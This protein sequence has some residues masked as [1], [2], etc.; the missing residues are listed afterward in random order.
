MDAY[1]VFSSYRSDPNAKLK[2]K[3]RSDPKQKIF[4]SISRCSYELVWSLFTELDSRRAF[5]D[6]PTKSELFTH[7]INEMLGFCALEDNDKKDPLLY[8]WN[9]RD[10]FN[11]SLNFLL[12]DRF[13]RNERITSI[14]LL[15]HRLIYCKES[16]LKNDC[17]DMLN[18]AYVFER[19]YDYEQLVEEYL[20]E[21][22]EN[23]ELR[24]YKDKLTNAYASLRNIQSKEK[25]Q[26]KQEKDRLVSENAEI[27]TKYKEEMANT[28]ILKTTIT[29]KDTEYKEY[30]NESRENEELREYEHFE[31][32]DYGKGYRI[33]RVSQRIE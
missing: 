14:R 7:V 17:I 13:S 6:I 1:S 32:D 33:Q 30:L 8:Q 24:E 4:S 27:Q 2:F 26:Y 10:Y 23:E 31:D 25:D 28:N 21:S 15:K 18:K 5:F 20:N 3:P 22:R 12:S 9:P 29:E 19:I 16:N 11:G